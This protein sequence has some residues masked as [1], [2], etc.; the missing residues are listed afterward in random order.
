MKRAGLFYDQVLGM[1]VLESKDLSGYAFAEGDGGIEVLL[2]ENEGAC[3]ETTVACF[4]V[5]DI[6]K[7]IEDLQS[8][9]VELEKV[10]TDQYSTDEDGI[11]TLSTSRFAWFKDTEG[12][13]LSIAQ[14]DES[15]DLD[16]LQ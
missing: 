8:K 1:R 4:V 3:H 13:L 15:L 6:E 11:A 5:E 9:G 2:Y 16:T 14:F 7:E 10:E 12:N